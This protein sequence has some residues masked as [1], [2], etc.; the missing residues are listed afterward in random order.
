MIRKSFGVKLSGNGRRT[1]LGESALIRINRII[2]IVIPKMKHTNY[3]LKIL[4]PP[5]LSSFEKLTS[6]PIEGRVKSIYVFNI[7]LNCN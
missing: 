1:N 3:V 4:S 5:M 6:M 2:I 7:L